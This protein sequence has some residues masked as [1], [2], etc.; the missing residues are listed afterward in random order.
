MDHTKNEMRIQIGDVCCSFVCHNTEVLGNLKQLFHGF[1]SIS[2]PDTIVV[3]EDSGNQLSLENTE[4]AMA[5]AKYIHEG[6]KFYTHNH[7]IK[8]EHDDTGRVIRFTSERHLLNPDSEQNVLNHLLSISYY[9]ACRAKYDGKPPAMLVHASGIVRNNRSF[10]FSGPCDIGKSSIA[11]MCAD[12][13]GQVVNDEILLVSR[14]GPDN[15]G[16]S[17]I[18]TPHLGDLKPEAN[19]TAPLACGLLLKQGHQTLIRRLDIME[20]YIRFMRQIITP[21]YIGQTDRKAIHSL[22]ADF[23]KEIIEA[24]PFYELEFTLNRQELWTVLDKL[25][26]SLVARSAK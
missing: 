22:I 19:I 5:E 14:P 26:E 12:P 10:I 17:L 13:Y 2:Q 15:N 11:R 4:A 7:L 1:L 25:E 20:A 9:T 6:D 24:V 16:I 23:S 18:S 8:G 3:L 21:A